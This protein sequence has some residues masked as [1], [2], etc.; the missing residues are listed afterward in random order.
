MKLPWYLKEYGKPVIE[1]GKY[2][3]NIKV[4]W[5]YRLYARFRYIINVCIGK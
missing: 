4:H 3:Q 1:N 2:I 5:I